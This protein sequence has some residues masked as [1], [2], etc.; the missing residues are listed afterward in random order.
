M[1][2]YTVATWD[3]ELLRELLSITTKLKF[4]RKRHQFAFSQL[5]LKHWSQNR[6]T[7]S[8]LKR[9]DGEKRGRRVTIIA[10]GIDKTE[11]MSIG[12]A[13]WQGKD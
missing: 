9:K 12:Y 13:D 3:D 8:F 2:V 1:I 10:S 7:A 5:S 4:I 6:N 11:M